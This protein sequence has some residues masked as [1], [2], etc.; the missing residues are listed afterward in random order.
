MP[1]VDTITTPHPDIE[2]AVERSPLGYSSCAPDAGVNSDTGLVLFLVGYGM[3]ARGPYARNLLS[4]L[5]NK[6]NCVAASVEYFGA[7]LMSG[8][9]GKIV[10]HPSFGDKFAEHYGLS[11]AAWDALP[12]D[13]LLWRVTGAL[14]EDGIAALHEECTVIRTAKEYNSMGFLPA[15]DGLQV[16]HRLLTALSLNRT[17]VF[18]LGTSYGGYVAG[19][20]AKLAPRTFRMVV[21]NSGFS[22]PEDNSA[23]VLGWQRL[24]IN[25]VW[26]MGRTAIHWSSD[27]ALGSFFSPERRAIRNLHHREHVIDNTARTYAY[28]AAT[29][30]YAPVGRKKRLRDVYK[31]RMPYELMIV[32]EDQIDGKIFKNAGHGLGASMRGVFEMSYEK[33]IRDGGALSDQT[34]FDHLSEYVFAC[35]KENYVMKF[36]LEHGVQAQIQAASP[37]SRGST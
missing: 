12:F 30:T 11:K 31:G 19:L 5:A 4:H 15:L 18:L 3:A 1:P 37:S 6:H 22:T 33:F 28:H 25:K 21:D 17:R 35:G 27:P 13:D 10:P 34:D 29:D 2:L 7:K 36:S 16:V 8:A 9:D 24:L 23:A 14:S 26:V 32:D 20:M